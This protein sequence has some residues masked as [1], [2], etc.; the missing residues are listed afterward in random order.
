MAGLHPVLTSLKYSSMQKSTVIT[1]SDIDGS[2][3]PFFC[4]LKDTDGL[5]PTPL[6]ESE[7]WAPHQCPPGVGSKLPL[8]LYADVGA[9]SDL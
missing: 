4:S 3:T 5:A 8:P 1:A 6:K 7:G 2:S 9:Y